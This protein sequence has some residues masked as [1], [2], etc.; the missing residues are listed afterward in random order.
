MDERSRVVAREWSLAR[1]ELAAALREFLL[2]VRHF[3]GKR[4]R[5]RRIPVRYQNEV[6]SADLERL[7]GDLPEPGPGVYLLYDQGNML[8]YVGKAEKGLR[9]RLQE[10]F[11]WLRLVRFQYLDGRVEEVFLVSDPESIEDK[12]RMVK[13]VITIS[14]P[15][16]FVFLVPALEAFLISFLGPP[17]NKKDRVPLPERQRYLTRLI[18]PPWGP[19]VVGQ[20]FRVKEG[21]FAWIPPGAVGKVIEAA[22]NRVRVRFNVEL[23]EWFGP[24]EFRDTFGPGQDGVG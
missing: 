10:H 17:W 19:K 2:A 12:H 23:V 16:E 1:E 6:S 22:D 15:A 18:F 5:V 3:G 20:S 4:L 9:K 13:W 7:A 14:P 8:L 21:F 24:D 11:A